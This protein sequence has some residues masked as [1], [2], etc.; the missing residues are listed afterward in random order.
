MRLT[1][2]SLRAMNASTK[3]RTWYPTKAD[4]TRAKAAEI[5]QQAV[6]LGPKRPGDWR[7]AARL[8]AT[9]ARL[10]QQASDYL[11]KVMRYEEAGL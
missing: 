5:D 8:R 3:T 6:T 10:H 4:W 9:A 1:L 7:H 11:V 2:A